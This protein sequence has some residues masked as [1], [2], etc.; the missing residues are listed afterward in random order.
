MWGVSKSAQITCKRRE[1]NWRGKCT[2]DCKATWPPKS[3]NPKH[4]HI[5]RLVSHLSFVNVCEIYF[6]HSSS[7][8][9]YL[10]HCFPFVPFVL[11]PSCPFFFFPFPFLFRVFPVPFSF[12]FRFCLFS[13]CFL[14]LFSFLFAILFALWLYFLHLSRYAKSRCLAISW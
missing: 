5:I 11:F 13:L 9:L 3:A 6:L 4:G 12:L 1:I 10:F 14:F 7:I 2:K 8:A